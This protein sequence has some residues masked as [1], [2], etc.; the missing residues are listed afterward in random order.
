MQTK[1]MYIELKTGYSDNGPA[2]IGRG[3]FSK[4]GKTIYFNNKGFKRYQGIFS[5]YRDIETG[6]NYWISGVKKNGD[7]RHWL[8]QE[9]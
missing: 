1:I 2:W 8:A 4:S 7:D 9:K 6:E 5:N 3:A